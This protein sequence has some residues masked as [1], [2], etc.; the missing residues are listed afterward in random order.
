MTTHSD[1]AQK[2]L[3][4]GA[5]LVSALLLACNAAVLA[6][7]E[8]AGDPLETPVRTFYVSKKGD[9]ADG[10]SWNTAWNELALINWEEVGPGDL[11][12]IDGGDVS[13]TYDT[14]LTFKK[15][16]VQGKPIVLRA[17]D[18]PGRSGQVLLR[19][20]R[21]SELPYCG[22]SDFVR[23]PQQEVRL[24]GIDTNQ[25]SWI[26]VDGG[27]WRGIKV[28]GFAG[29]GIEVNP[30]SEHLTFRNVEVTD[31][32]SAAWREDGTW[33]PFGA[34]VRL[35]GE[36]ILFDRALVHDNGGDGFRIEGGLS[37]ITLRRSWIYNSRPHP[38]DKDEPFNH[39]AQPNGVHVAPVG[40]DQY[41]FK[42]EESIVG[43]GFSNGLLLA[44]ARV[45]GEWGVLHDVWLKNV[46]LVSHHGPS[47]AANL[48]AMQ[49]PG[50]PPRNWR[51]EQVTSLRGVDAQLAS[52]AL[53][54]K[55]HTLERV[56][57]VGG[58]ELYFEEPN[59]LD[60][61]RST[62][63]KGTELGTSAEL[64]LKDTDFAGVGADFAAFDLS[65]DNASPCAGIGSAITSPSVLLMETE[66]PT[67]AEVLPNVPPTISFLTPSMNDEVLAG[68][69]V[70][71]TA[72]ADDAD[73][74][75]IKVEFLT[76]AGTPIGEVPL[77]PFTLTFSPA[78]GMNELIA[79]AWDDDG[80]FVDA[81]VQF[82]GM[83]IPKV[84]FEAE[85]MTLAN[86]FG[87]AG[88]C[89]RQTVTTNTVGQGGSARY[90]F[91]ITTA[92][93]YRVRATVTS[94][95]G[96]ENSFFINIDANPQGT[97]IWDT[98]VSTTPVEELANWRGNGSPTA[99]QFSPKTFNL[100][101]G[102][103]ELVLMGREANTCID[104]V[105]IELV[106]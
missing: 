13:M 90:T 9:G 21:S 8:G 81:T 16:G 42:V 41:G 103:H 85:D 22:Q 53:R 48:S 50:H 93:T 65:F 28:L 37:N 76:T 46:T 95:S 62:T 69:P 24:N 66:I 96:G 25:Q 98:V 87:V 99:P 40:E 68:E 15:S 4:L 79:R 105:T 10:R 14:L 23:Q 97:H 26:L 94:P 38:T 54:G 49:P 17:S 30:F 47:A 12:L 43:P 83:G 44:N 7:V 89:V 74:Q 77:A 61:C 71:I 58:G 33:Y 70:T 67:V 18:E 45:L 59:V 31:N 57:F 35:A 91:N 11:I 64:V 3:K 34:G 55:G 104:K 63:V 6:E 100:D 84:E 60:S 32:G 101:A 56:L 82:M 5:L 80:A 2:S 27:K 36:R 75:I 86:E 1:I 39:C 78:E 72:T 52:V 20:G 51:L 19:G 102:E 88:D 73:G 29:P 92:G 106:P